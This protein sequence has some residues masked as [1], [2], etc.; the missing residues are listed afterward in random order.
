MNYTNS[1]T[2]DDTQRWSPLAI[3]AEAD[4]RVGLSGKVARTPWSDFL[5]RYG[6]MSIHEAELFHCNSRISTASQVNVPLP[7]ERIDELRAWLD[8][9]G[10]V[11]HE[12]AIDERE[13]ERT[14]FTKVNFDGV[15][16][17]LIT[18][19][20]VNTLLAVELYFCVAGMLYRM[21]NQ[22]LWLERILSSE[23]AKKM[24][25]CL[26][27]EQP[28]GALEVRHL[29]LYVGFPWRYMV[30]QGPRGYRRML[31]ELGMQISRVEQLL[32]A[33]GLAATTSLDFY[34]VTVESLLGFDGVETTL[35]ATTAALSGNDL[36]DAA[37][38]SAISL[39]SLAGNRG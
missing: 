13:S 32:Q 8:R 9:E 29:I 39:Q 6:T 15:L 19:P 14:G 38:Q 1:N 27:L 21:R 31:V 25:D 11:P 36:D 30:L 26:H 7:S 35:L 16:R 10:Y 24:S 28:N 23:D 4:L 33:A 5:D 18:A 34:D 17:R 20:E 3:L 2:Q 22:R 37:D 12:D